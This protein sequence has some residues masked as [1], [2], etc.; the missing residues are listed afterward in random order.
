[1]TSTIN[2][3]FGDE[4]VKLARYPISRFLSSPHA[5]ATSG[6]IS[7][8]TPGAGGF[9]AIGMGIG[10][11][12]GA[13]TLQ[14]TRAR[15]VK[16]LLARAG[17]GGEGLMKHERKRLAEATGLTRKQLDDALER[18]G[19]KQ[20]ANTKDTAKIE[21]ALT[22]KYNPLA[23]LGRVIGARGMAGR[24]ARGGKG[25]QASEK[26]MLEAIKQEH[27]RRIRRKLGLGAAAGGAAGL[28]IKKA[29]D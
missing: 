26:E 2:T 3:S 16:A 5:A 7:S 15:G 23:A 29:T 27:K 1:M 25:L 11:L 22:W 19:R 13:S 9:N 28:G 21:R 14:G 20:L 6:A 10:S 12:L 4:L 18:V 8:V 24:A 17:Q